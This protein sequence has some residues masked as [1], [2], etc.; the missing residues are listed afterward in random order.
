M[1]FIRNHFLGTLIAVNVTGIIL[2]AAVVAMIVSSSTTTGRQHAEVKACNR[3]NV[4]TA[5]TNRTNRDAYEFDGL[6][7]QL[8][9]ASI[10]NQTASVPRTPEQTKATERFIGGLNH[11]KN[12]LDWL[13]PTDCHAATYDETYETP[14]PVKFSLASPPESVYT[15]G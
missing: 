12:D 2:L 14:Q 4:N 9:E 7:V 13:M 15:P 11:A 10:R 5:R 8:I 6:E 1:T 3:A